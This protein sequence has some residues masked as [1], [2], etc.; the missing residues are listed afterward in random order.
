M[1]V[2]H[3]LLS[4]FLYK[5]FFFLISLFIFTLSCSLLLY[6]QITLPM[7][8]S[9]KSA[10]LNTR[11]LFIKEKI[12]PKLSLTHFQNKFCGYVVCLDDGNMMMCTPLFRLVSVHGLASY[13]PLCLGS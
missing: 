7:Y 1:H 2:T 5:S 13:V 12:K 3:S 10:L 9:L 6:F 4:I 8:L 11:L